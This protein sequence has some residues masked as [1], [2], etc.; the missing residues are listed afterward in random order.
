MVLL[1]QTKLRQAFDRCSEKENLALITRTVQGVWGAETKVHLQL[2]EAAQKALDERVRNDPAVQALQK[3][4]QAVIEEVEYL[5]N[6][7]EEDD[8]EH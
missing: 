7:T 8:S 1:F 3:N 4:F 2:D 6:P 5:P